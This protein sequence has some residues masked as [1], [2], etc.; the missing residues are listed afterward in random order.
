MNDTTIF[1]ERS[2]GL[3]LFGGGGGLAQASLPFCEKPIERQGGLYAPIRIGDRRGGSPGIAQIGILQLVLARSSQAKS[4]GPSAI[5]DAVPNVISGS[6]VR[7][8]MTPLSL[9]V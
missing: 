6:V 5:M 9:G 2:S 8:R 4:A 7:V 1:K 3:Q